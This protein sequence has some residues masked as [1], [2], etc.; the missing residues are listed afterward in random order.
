[1]AHSDLKTL[2]CM[3]T[4][5]ALWACGPAAQEQ[6]PVDTTAPTASFYGDSI[7]AGTGLSVRPVDMMTRAAQGRWRGVDYAVDGATVQNATYGHPKLP[8]ANWTAQMAVDPSRVIIVGYSGASAWIHPQGVDE[9]A[10]LLMLMV[11]EAQR[12]SKV[13]LLRGMSHVARPIQGLTLDDDLRY[14]TALA[15]FHEATRVVAQQTGV[16]FIDLRAVSFNGTPDMLDGLHPNLE[17]SA[18]LSEQTAAAVTRVF[19]QRGQP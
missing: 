4:T 8:F 14:A 7:I 5:L 11:R 9:Y 13:V 18:R 15:D 10:G 12:H 19:T 3:L 1:M 2:A 16:E 6:T 17:Y